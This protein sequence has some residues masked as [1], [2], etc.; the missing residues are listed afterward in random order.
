MALVGFGTV[1]FYFMAYGASRVVLWTIKAL[2]WNLPLSVPN[3]AL[4]LTA[5]KVFVDLMGLRS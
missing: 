1:M 5:G 2:D 4:N 3:A